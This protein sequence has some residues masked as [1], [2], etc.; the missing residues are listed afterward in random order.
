MAPAHAA[1]R[2][3]RLLVLACSLDDTTAID[4]HSGA[5]VRL[6]VPWPEGHDPDLSPFDVVEAALADDPQ[7]DDLAQ[8]EAATVAGLPRQVGTLHGRHARRLLAALEAPPGGPLLGF[9]G[10][11]APYWDFRG[12][13]PSVALLHP[14]RGPQLIRRPDASTWVR[15]GWGRD[16]IWLPVTDAHAARALDAARQTRLAG[17]PLATALGF[18]PFYL[19]TSISAPRQGHCYKA[20]SAVLPRG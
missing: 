7:R 20:C 5:V 1:R 17:K 6:R 19:L 8:P 9:P 13:R 2:G 12:L 14:T 18:E 3:L 10:L 11:S 4:L 15:F 16:E